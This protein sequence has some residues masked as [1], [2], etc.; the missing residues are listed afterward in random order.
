MDHNLRTQGAPCNTW[1]E[2]RPIYDVEYADDILLLALTTMQMH[3]FLS[4]FEQGAAE[5]GMSL[6]S[7]KMELLVKKPGDQQQRGV[8]RWYTGF[9]LSLVA[10]QTGAL[11]FVQ[12]SSE[13]EEAVWLVAALPIALT[14]GATLRL[15]QLLAKKQLAHAFLDRGIVPTD[16]PHSGSFLDGCLV[17]AVLAYLLLVVFLVSVDV[18]TLLVAL[19]ALGLG[20][21]SRALGGSAWML[22]K[23]V[24]TAREMEQCISATYMTIYACSAGELTELTPA[25]SIHSL[26]FAPWQ[27]YY[28]VITDVSFQQMALMASVQPSM[29]RSMSFL[30]SITETTLV[31]LVPYKRAVFICH[32]SLLW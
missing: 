25:S 27:T 26:S 23:A 7:T 30:G 29:T 1:S 6:N 18:A 21:F 10:M 20:L 32:R 3:I 17:L 16:L 19:T 15:M 13:Q 9:L 2:G 8:Q 12:K 22:L 5:Y 14:L 24:S 11:S 31:Y 4:A 28:E